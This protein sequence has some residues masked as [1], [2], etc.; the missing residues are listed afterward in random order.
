M[1]AILSVVQ[2]SSPIQALLNGTKTPCECHKVSLMRKQ[3]TL[4]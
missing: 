3:S 4:L 2:R 1:E